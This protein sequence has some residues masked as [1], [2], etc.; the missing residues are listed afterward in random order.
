[1]TLS[2]SYK[3]SIKVKTKLLKAIIHLTSLLPICLLY[4]SAFNDELG[5]DPVEAVIHFTGI[6]AF[7]LLLLTLLVTPLA[8]QFK[9]GYLMKVRR[10]LGLYA[11]TYAFFHVLNFIAFDLQ[12]NLTLLFDEVV[13]RPYITIGLIAIL[14]LTALA[15][16]SINYFKRKMGKSWQKL[17]NAIYLI[18]LLVGIH[19]YWSV[20]SEVIE[21]TI[22]IVISFVLLYL[23][24][25]KFTL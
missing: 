23:R 7:N 10:L 6:G 4:L 12:F 14:L 19:F 1:M 22:Y 11:F 18:I 25:R 15:I 5:A 21:P 16:T 24:R 17:H 2:V 20:K 9:Q 8:K 13:K 3:L